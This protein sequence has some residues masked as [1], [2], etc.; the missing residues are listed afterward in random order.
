MRLTEARLKAYRDRTYRRTPARRVRSRQA[1]VD[2]VN[3]RGMIYFWPITG[4]E[5][6]SL[7]VAVAGDRPVADA[8]DDPGHVSWGW[9]DTLL[10]EKK[11]F[12]AKILRGR[13]TILSLKVASYFY[14]LS[15]NYGDPQDYLLQYEAGQMTAEAKQVYGTLLEKGKLDTLSLRREARLA[16]K[17]SNTRFERALVELQRDFKILPVGVAEAGAWKYAYVYELVGRWFPELAAQAR[18][19]GRGEARAYLAGIYLESV[20]AA[21]EG[22]M[23][24]LFGWRAE[25]VRRAGERLAAQGRA[26]R[27]EQVGAIPGPGWVTASLW[28]AG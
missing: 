23:T 2:F 13:A 25:E 8:H 15:E 10:S 28:C 27:V 16:G 17:E 14:A 4:V 11:W 24:R 6:P 22:Q 21:T 20:G 19:I 12:Y 3:E 1:A 5:L 7:W 26:Q 9:K 18:P